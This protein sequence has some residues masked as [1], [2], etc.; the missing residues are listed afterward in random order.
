M[1][2]FHWRVTVPAVG[3]CC[4]L[5]V[6]ATLGAMSAP[7]AVGH[8]S[9]QASRTAGKVTVVS[10]TAG[11]PTELGFKV[12][13]T[14]KLPNGT[15]TF[16]VTN[17]G[18]AFHDFKI[19]TIPI[20]VPAGA[21]NSCVGKGTKILHHGQ[22]A[23]LTVKFTAPGLYEFL[24]TVTGHAAAGMKGLL[25]VGVSVTATQEKQAASASA[26]SSSGAGGGSTTTSSGGHSA[27]G[28][29]TSGCPPGVT[30][31]SSGNTDADGDELGT[32]PDDNDGC[33]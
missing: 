28:G 13:Q 4:G 11:K 8:A 12:S 19:C 16:K 2:R 15:V 33:V 25:G 5:G 22:S 3:V 32:E 10:V 7:A 9:K 14:S 20:P 31:K 21:M 1:R 6:L 24:C 30:I 29:D 26:G 18:V 17:A 27:G 23:T